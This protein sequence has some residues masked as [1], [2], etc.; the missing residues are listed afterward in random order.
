M[1]VETNKAVPLSCAHHG[2]KLSLAQALRVQFI[3]Q[4]VTPYDILT[5]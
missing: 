1:N 3:T 5:T 2:T 4:S